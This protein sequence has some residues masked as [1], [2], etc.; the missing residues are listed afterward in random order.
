MQKPGVGQEIIGKVILEHPFCKCSV[1]KGFVVPSCIVIPVKMLYCQEVSKSPSHTW[2]ALVLDVIDDEKWMWLTQPQSRCRVRLQHVRASCIICPYVLNPQRMH[3]L[4]LSLCY[5]AA[6]VLG[7][8]SLGN[9]QRGTW[10]NSG[11]ERGVATQ[12]YPKVR[13]KVLIRHKR[14]YLGCTRREPY[15]I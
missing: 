9:D 10:L 12:A 6:P 3:S 13:A 5:G 7:Q 14:L 1:Q 11:E 2:T 4:S 8:R 15:A